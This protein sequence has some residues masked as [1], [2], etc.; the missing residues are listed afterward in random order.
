MTTDRRVLF[1]A[2]ALLLALLTLAALALRLWG[3]GSPRA[4]ARRGQQ[5]LLRPATPR[6]PALVAV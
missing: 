4:A 2:D 1:R 6:Y 3:P 5:P